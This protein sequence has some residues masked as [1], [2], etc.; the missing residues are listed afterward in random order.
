MHFFCVGTLAAEGLS[1]L[2]MKKRMKIEMAKRHK[3][4]NP[5]VIVST[6]RLCVHNV[7]RSVDDK[8]LRVSACYDIKS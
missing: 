3:L 1:D 4:K 5:N 7:P 6:T 2:E 8:Q